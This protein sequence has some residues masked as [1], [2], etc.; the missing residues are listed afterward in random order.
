M[1][2]EYFSDEIQNNE[3]KKYLSIV[4]LFILLFSYLILNL[5]LSTIPKKS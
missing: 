5:Y 2:K 4:A 1:K 3:N